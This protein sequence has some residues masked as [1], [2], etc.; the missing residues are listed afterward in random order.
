[1]KTSNK[2]AAVPS[3]R[4]PTCIS[5][6]MAAMGSSATSAH[7]YQIAQRLMPEHSMSSSQP[8]LYGSQILHLPHC[9][10]WQLIPP[11]VCALQHY[12]LGFV[13]LQFVC[14]FNTIS[15]QNT[16]NVAVPCSGV[17]IPTLLHMHHFLWHLYV[18]TKS[19]QTILMAF[20]GSTSCSQVPTICPYVEP[21]KSS[22]CPP[23]FAQ[24]STLKLTYHLHLHLPSCLSLRISC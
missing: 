15:K 16:M 4:D 13:R 18:V 19:C 3:C 23:T 11:E 8:P 22:P 21:E 6:M 14:I 7:T 17:E 20:A 9:G 5:L 2:S 24:T 12:T 1:M 10:S